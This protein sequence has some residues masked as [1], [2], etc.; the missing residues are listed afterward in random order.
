MI[1]GI[2]EDLDKIRAAGLLRRTRLVS[3]KQS[4]SVT[5]DGRDVL[6]LCSNNY[7]G[8]AEHPALIEASISAVQRC[9]ASSGASRLVSGTMELHEELERAV[10]GFKRTEAALV[11]NSG[12]AANSGIIP[13]LVGRGD[14][15]FSDRLNHASIIDGIQL[16]AARMVR[17]PH[18]DVR[19]LGWLLD[20]HRDGGRKLIV[21]DGVFS[22]DG[23]IAPLAELVALKDQH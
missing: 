7:L 23:D 18:N 4:S 5:L 12:Y 1:G 22:M 8:L 11:F 9:G 15:V 6:L 13:A 10:A 14:T 21:S 2:R 16:S 19:Q 17:Y 20:K 3:G